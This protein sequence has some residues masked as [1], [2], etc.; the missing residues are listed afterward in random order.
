ML[1]PEQDAFGQV[2]LAGLRGECAREI[3]ERDDGLFDV[4]PGPALY[5]SEHDSWPRSVRDA[6]RLVQG[7]VLD[8][9]CGA[10]RHALYLQSLG[11]DVLGTD[12][13]P[14][15]LEVCRAR[16]LRETLLVSITGLSRRL[17]EFDTILMLGNNFGLCGSPRR[18]RWLMTRFRSMTSPEACII[19]QSVDPLSTEMPDHLAYHQ[20]NRDR[21]RAPG[22]LR[23]RV[24]YR[25]YVTPWFGL[26]L[27][28]P[29]EMATI[30]EGTGWTIVQTLTDGGAGYLAVMEKEP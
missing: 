18:A 15:A 19:A 28:S 5:F 13:S 30:A 9:G 11:H 17:G 16:G 10:G 24:R 29:D 27:V 21:G 6:M 20:R 8:V 1:T 23:I 4:G 3:I 22:E 7:R 2:L 14:G 25:R 26:L 12:I